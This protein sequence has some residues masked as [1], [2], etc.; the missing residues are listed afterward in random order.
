VQPANQIIFPR[1][2]ME[3]PLPFADPELCELLEQHTKHSH[4]DLRVSKTPLQDVR[5]VLAHACG[6]V[7]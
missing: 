7:V 2:L 3:M 5:D 6:R 4:Q 1:D